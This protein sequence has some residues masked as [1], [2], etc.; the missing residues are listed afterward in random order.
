MNIDHENDHK[1]ETKEPDLSSTPLMEERLA[2]IE[3]SYGVYPIQNGD[4][5][6]EGR[7][8]RICRFYHETQ[9]K[10]ML[11]D[12]L[13]ERLEAMLPTNYTLDVRRSDTIACFLEKMK[14]FNSLQS[15]QYKRLYKFNWELLIAL[16]KILTLAED[17][18]DTPT[19]TN[20]LALNV[21]FEL[22]R[23]S[24]SDFRDPIKFP[25][26]LPYLGGATWQE[27]LGQEL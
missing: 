19:D 21:A 24:L 6:F 13:F 16:S 26:P 11:S 4:P 2:A 27:L 9:C 20:L 8:D 25:F 23:K 17:L 14:S 22:I 12:E 15:E 3:A 7:I 18:G 1:K 5:S 10:K